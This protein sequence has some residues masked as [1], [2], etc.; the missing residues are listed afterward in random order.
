[1]HGVANSKEIQYI[2]RTLAIGMLA[3]ILALP[4]MANGQGWKGVPEH[5]KLGPGS[6]IK[7]ELLYVTAVVQ[8][9]SYRQDKAM[10]AARRKSLQRALQMIY[11]AVPCD[12]LIGDMPEGAKDALFEILLPFIRSAHIQGLTVIRQW[13]S[14]QTFYTTVSV[15]LKIV[16]GIKCEIPDIPTG[17]A[18]YISLK[19]VSIRGLEFCLSRSSRYSQLNEGVRNRIG[20]WYLDRNL[21]ALARCFLPDAESGRPFSPLQA[22]LFQ[23]RLTKAERLARKAEEAHRDG[24][25]GI[26]LEL[27]SSA[28]ELV[29]TLSR[30]YLLLARYFLDQEQRPAFAL[31]A[32]ERAYQDGANF[33]AALAIELK[34]LE[35]TKSPEA[36]IFRYLITQTQHA[37]D[38]SCPEAWKNEMERLNGLPVPC[39]VIPSR[40]QLVRGTAKRPGDRLAQAVDLYGKAQSEEEVR[41]VLDLLLKNIQE[42]PVVALS[43][44]LVGACY[45]HLNQPDLALPFLWQALR[46]EPDYDLALTNLGLCCQSL[47]LTQSAGF[48]FGCRAVQDSKNPWVNKSVQNFHKTNLRA[49]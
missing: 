16:R 12:K 26:A 32:V 17:I 46:L 43:H 34:I 20:R 48:Y 40:G 4:A 35:Q 28:I 25:W 29:P 9:G 27:V 23:N 24:K 49:K 13:E 15:P 8:A 14:G 38:G 7:G 10:E 3:G 42:N 31:C 1:M 37:P 36:E 47:G 30:S 21:P 45:R 18:R 2:V 19:D 5:L 22:A 11:L 6:A 44:N 41:S 33:Q 39:L